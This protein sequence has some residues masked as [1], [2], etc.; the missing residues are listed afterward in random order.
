MRVFHAR[1]RGKAIRKF[2]RDLRR[3]Q[4]WG[5]AAGLVNAMLARFGGID[6]FA[7]T[8]VGMIRQAQGDK[9]AAKAVLESLQAIMRL[10]EL[11]HR[12]NPEPD[13]SEMTDEQL[14]ESML[15]AAEQAC[16]NHPELAIA[17]AQRLGWKVIPPPE[18]GPR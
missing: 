16:I 18:A 13:V 14:R 5:R 15:R 4:S 11:C 3:E 2:A 1:R 9:A 6:R 17:A 8:W 7:A 10:F 12:E